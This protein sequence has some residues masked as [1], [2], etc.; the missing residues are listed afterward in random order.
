MAILREDHL[1]DADRAISELRRIG[2]EDID[3]AGLALVEIYRRRED[4]AKIPGRGDRGVRADRLPACKATSLAT[5]V[6]DAYAL[7]APS[8]RPAE[9]A[10]QKRPR[11]RS[12]KRAPFAP[13]GELYPALP[14]S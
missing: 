9:P 12:R 7:V 6:A 13:P 5:R 1:F 2:P 11:P 10:L 14:G 3:S 8:L 4:P